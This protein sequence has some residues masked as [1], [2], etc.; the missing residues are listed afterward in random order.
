MY[1][2]PVPCGI[3]LVGWLFLYWSAGPLFI[4]FGLATLAAGV[5]VFLMW[6]WRTRQWPF[7]GAGPDGAPVVIDKATPA[8]EGPS[9]GIVA[10]PQAP[11]TLRGPESLHSPAD[12][13]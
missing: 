11:E 6:A 3:A 1:L 4:A 8:A 5:L 12:G 9:T 2:Y 7:G 10:A 13:E